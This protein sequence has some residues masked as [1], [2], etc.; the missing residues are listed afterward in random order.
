MKRCTQR[1]VHPSEDGQMNTSGTLNDTMPRCDKNH[2]Q[3][4]R[5]ELREYSQDH[6]GGDRCGD[7]IFI[8]GRKYRPGPFARNRSE[9]HTQ[10]NQIESDPNAVVILF[11]SAVLSS[12]RYLSPSPSRWPRIH[13]VVARLALSQSPR[14]K[15]ERRHQGSR[16]V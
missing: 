3:T 11:F 9:R 7:I 4:G 12:S 16:L 5:E 1:T 10:R 6:G 13:Q 14:W 2:R 8:G 15:W